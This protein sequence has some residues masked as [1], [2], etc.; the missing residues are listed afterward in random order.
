MVKAQ[1]MRGFLYTLFHVFSQY[2]PVLK[3]ETDY[4]CYIENNIIRKISGYPNKIKQR[5]QI[6]S[7][8]YLHPI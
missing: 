1:E 6:Y 3:A 7:K 2:Y 4:F 5:R 8:M